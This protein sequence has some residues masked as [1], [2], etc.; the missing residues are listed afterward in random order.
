M[1]KLNHINHSQIN[2]MGTY[3]KWLTKSNITTALML[4][5]VLAMLVSPQFKGII[6]QGLMKI[7]L[8]QPSVPDKSEQESSAVLYSTEKGREMLFEDS[9]GKI[10]NLSD[11]KGKV[12]FINFWATWCPPCIAEMPSI[13]KLKSKFKDNPNVVFIMLDMDSDLKKSLKFMERKTYDLDVYIPAS[14]ISGDYFQ[15][16]LP[17]T[18]LFNK[19][20]K[21]VFKHE[22]GA[23]Y[24][25]TEF[26]KFLEKTSSE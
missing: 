4:I 12:V 23:D 2:I 25:N 17:T 13:N 8:F 22:G 7:G 11:L 26:E 6:I 10:T 19:S 15:G 16:A 20:G 24:S 5:F 21:L 18:L 3:K 9:E 14:Q 1:E